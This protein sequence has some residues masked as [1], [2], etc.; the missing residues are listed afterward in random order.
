MPPG[1]DSATNTDFPRG[2]GAVDTLT[3]FWLR[4][5]LKWLYKSY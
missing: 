3:A 4:N 1:D 5:D 2:A